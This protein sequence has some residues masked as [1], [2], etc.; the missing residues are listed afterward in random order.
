MFTLGLVA[1]LVS[2]SVLLVQGGVS[3]SSVCEDG[4]ET[5][6]DHETWKPQPCLSCRCDNGNIKCVLTLCP[7]L[8]DCRYP[9]VVPEGECCPVCPEVRRPWLKKPDG[10]MS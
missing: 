1:L 5:Y 3:P 10:Q 6:R 8:R 2:A 4:G 7:R 9:S